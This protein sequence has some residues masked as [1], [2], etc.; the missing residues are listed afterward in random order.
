MNALIV[1]DCDNVVVAIAPISQGEAVEYTRHDGQVVS[2][3]AASDIPV[4]HKIAASDITK[5]APVIKYGETI[6]TAA[7]N[8][9]RG[10]HVHVHNI[11]D[12]S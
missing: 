11:A 12:L 7:E 9:A 8:I 10:S 1:E 5:G 4:Y 6:C 2:F 3:P